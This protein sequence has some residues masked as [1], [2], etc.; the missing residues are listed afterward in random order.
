MFI[1]NFKAWYAF[2]EVT[3]IRYLKYTL[4]TVYNC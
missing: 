2:N 4:I 3:K 1:H